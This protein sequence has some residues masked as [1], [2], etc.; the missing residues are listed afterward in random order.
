MLCA[1]I[2][3]LFAV[4]TALA[5]GSSRST[6]DSLKAQNNLAYTPEE[7]LQ[8]FNRFEEELQARP[9]PLSSDELAELYEETKPAIM[10]SLVDEVNSKQNLWTA[11]TEQG[12]FY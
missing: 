10:Q 11:S 1:V 7:E 2:T 6:F 4:A 5:D 9:V 8:H 3:L 12:R